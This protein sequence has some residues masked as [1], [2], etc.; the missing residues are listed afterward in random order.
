MSDY[1]LETVIDGKSSKVMLSAIP[2][3]LV[4]RF[5]RVDRTEDQVMLVEKVLK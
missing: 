5:Y 2:N 4:V 3:S 1:L